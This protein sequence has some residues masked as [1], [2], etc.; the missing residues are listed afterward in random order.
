MAMA[1]ISVVATQN[2]PYRS[3][4]AAMSSKNAP[5]G[6]GSSEPLTRLSTCTVST[7][8]RGW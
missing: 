1:K 8:K 5:R 2:G 4:L 3:G 6:L 7:S